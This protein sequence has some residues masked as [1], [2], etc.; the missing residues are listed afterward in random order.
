MNAA[1]A[2]QLTI[3]V[4]DNSNVSALLLRPAEPRAAYVFAHGAGAGMAHPSMQT[5]AA[6]LAE[7]GI[8]TLR[9]QFPYM[10]K[11][12]GR[13]DPPAVAQATVRAAVA[14]AARRCGDL[15][16]FAGGKSFGGRMTSQAQAK[17]PL[18]GVR[19]LVFLG[20]PLHAAGKPS[21]ERAAH[22]AE[23]KIPM[24]F[25]QGTRDA[26]AELDLLQPMVRG[27]GARATLQL[28]KEA[29]HSFHVLKRSG[30]NDGEVMAEVL[31]A[32]AAWVTKLS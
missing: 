9:Y 32:F 27:L 2:E 15:P 19:A 16:L 23:V 28:V 3:A 1:G 10:E 8:A 14:E 30:R 13:P 18:A 26:L 24:L 21:S 20:F 17:A 11:G 5:I 31:D 7:R 29:D 6:G 12:S 4:S 25:L 22:L